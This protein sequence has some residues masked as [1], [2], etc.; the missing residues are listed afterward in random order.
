M[1]H[2]THHVALA[3]LLVAG[4]SACGLQQPDPRDSDSYSYSEPA[5]QVPR[6]AEPP[7]LIGTP[8]RAA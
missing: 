8:D 5:T 4:L 2:K 7:R 6:P 3:I 1:R